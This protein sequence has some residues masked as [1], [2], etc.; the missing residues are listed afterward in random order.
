MS[1]EHLC[2]PFPSA[3]LDWTEGGCGPIPQCAGNMSVKQLRA[4]KLYQVD[5]TTFELGWNVCKEVAGHSV[6][7]LGGRFPCGG[8]VAGTLGGLAAF[9]DE[10]HTQLQSRTA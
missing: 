6:R 9:V 3:H 4:G 7:G 10:V 1:A 5:P 8:A 2:F